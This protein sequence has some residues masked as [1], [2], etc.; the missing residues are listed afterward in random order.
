MKSFMHFLSHQSE[1]VEWPF[2]LR[3]PSFMSRG[4]PG[5]TGNPQEGFI[6]PWDEFFIFIAGHALMCL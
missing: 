4:C 3:L 2:P 6:K 5:N 1:L